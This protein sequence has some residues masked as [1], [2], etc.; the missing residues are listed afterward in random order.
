VRQVLSL[1]FFYERQIGL[2]NGLSELGL[3]GPHQLGLRERPAEA[4]QVAFELPELPKL[5]T[6][7]HYD[8]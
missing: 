4:P 3:D 6:E 2:G 8:P 1:T 7:G 5:L